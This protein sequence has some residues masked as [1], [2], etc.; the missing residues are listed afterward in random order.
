[1]PISFFFKYMQRCHKY[2]IKNLG[3]YYI[4]KENLGDITYIRKS[5]Q[6]YICK[7]F[8]IILHLQGI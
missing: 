5:A 3:Q 1:M 8:G 6:L 2:L 7:E 4:C